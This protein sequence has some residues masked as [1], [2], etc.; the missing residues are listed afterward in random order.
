MDESL[1]FEHAVIDVRPGTEEEFA[2]VWSSAKAVIESAAGC[3]AA[4]LLRGIESPSR[5]VLLVHW[6]SVEAHMEGFRES[7]KFAEWRAIVGPF[8]DGAPDVGHLAEVVAGPSAEAGAR[9]D[10]DLDR[11]LDEEED[12]SFP[13][14]D[15]HSDWAG[16]PT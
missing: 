9:N 15:A 4:R 11:R 8:F 5:F 7:E 12:D 10:T 14:S 13:A 3:Q 16:P 6:H 2:R 1:I